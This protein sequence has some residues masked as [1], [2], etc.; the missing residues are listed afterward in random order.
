MDSSVV[1]KNCSKK[2]HN[3]GNCMEEIQ[4][5]LFVFLMRSIQLVVVKCHN[6]SG[7]K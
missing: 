2:S 3:I 6:I 1:I 7:S 5:T 4:L